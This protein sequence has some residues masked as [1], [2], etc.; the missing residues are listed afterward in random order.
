MGFSEMSKV[1][2]GGSWLY[3][4]TANIAQIIGFLNSF[5]KKEDV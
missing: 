5:E 1:T 2:L 3:N 4:M